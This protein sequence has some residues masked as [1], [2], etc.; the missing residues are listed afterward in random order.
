MLQPLSVVIICKNEVAIIGRTLQSLQGLTDDIVVYDNGSTDG[1]QSIVQQ[2]NVQLH[3]GAW[4]GFGKTKGKATQL[5]KYD[6]ILNLDADEAIDEEL[7]QSLQQFA[8]A[9]EKT[10]FDLRFKNYLGDQH[11]KYGEW[12]GDHHIR[13]YNRKW[14]QWDEAPVHENLLLPAEASVK[15]L[16]GFVLHQTMKDMEEYSRKMLH[17]AML[18]AEKYKRQGKKASWFKLRLSPAFTFFN[19]YIIKLGFL[20]G[21]AGYICAK[22]TA[23]YT[24]LKYA[25]L[26]EITKTGQ[27]EIR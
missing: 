15:R 20:D 12:G 22:M 10:V 19:Y 26:R 6:W 2:F 21:H 5:A 27:G 7:K 3:E 24:F 16:K 1:T 18:N 8:A 25:R 13:V 14:V 9:D 23:W 17:Y 4:E 11:L